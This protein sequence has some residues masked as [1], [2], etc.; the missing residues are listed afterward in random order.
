M[1]KTVKMLGSESKEATAYEEKLQSGQS[2]LGEFSKRIGLATSLFYFI[3]NCLA[4]VGFI[5]GIQ[6][7]YG[8]NFCPTSAT[9]SRYKLDE[10]LTVLFTVFFCAFNFLQ[11]ASN[12]SA[13]KSAI[14]SSKRI[15]TFI[16]RPK[17]IK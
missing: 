10:F 17:V 16:N 15:Y 11:L 4:G 9:G 13:I 1:V 5:M 2:K 6:C 8:T 12:Y 7:M 3:I 14:Q